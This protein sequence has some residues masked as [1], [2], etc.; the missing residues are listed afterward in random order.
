MVSSIWLTGAF[1]EDGF[2]D[3][4]DGFGGGWTKEQKLHI[5]K[6][7]RLGTYG[8]IGLFMI[9]LLKYTILSHLFAKQIIIT[10]V[11][12]HAMSRL[13]PIFIIYFY[14]Y[15][16]EDASS[17]VKPIGKSISTLELLFAMF[18]ALVPL[19]YI[20]PETILCLP[21]VIILQFILGKYFKK[22]LGGYTGDCLGASQQVTEII[23]YLAFYVLWNFSL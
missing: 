15:A 4:C 14:E 11:S 7:S 13:T 3:V 22:H 12:V 20:G 8:S 19:F 23:L 2:S 5:M 18:I 1:H 10:L 21:I 6:D 16:R 17:K 9:L